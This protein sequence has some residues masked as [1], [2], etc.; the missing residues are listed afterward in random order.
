MGGYLFEF[1]VKLRQRR[2]RLGLPP[3]DERLC[4]LAVSRAYL[5][6]KNRRRTTFQSAYL[7]FFE[8]SIG[9]ALFY[10]A[11]VHGIEFQ[12]LKLRFFKHKFYLMLDAN[13]FEYI[14]T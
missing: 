12:Y 7:L 6:P 1:S 14:K 5:N 2:L 9:R 13:S 10:Q 3:S 4:T 11:L 8:S